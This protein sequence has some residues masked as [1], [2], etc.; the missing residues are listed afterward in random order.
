MNNAVYHFKE[1]QNE[2]MLGYLPGSVER[3]MLEKELDRQSS[4]QI[5]I[6]LIIGGKEIKTGKTGT[7]VMPHNHGHI[8]ATY[9]LATEKEVNLEFA[10]KHEIRAYPTLLFL[11]ADENIIHIDPVYGKLRN[12]Y[13]QDYSEK[14][15]AQYVCP[16]C[17]T[18]LI[19]ENIL[20]PKCA[21]PVAFNGG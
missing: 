13:T 4:D 6:P 5:E 15:E 1:P 19:E 10:K 7:V 2:E 17:N 21:S 14:R 3:K 18:S 9:H 16:E 11:D 12:I 20:C 8:L